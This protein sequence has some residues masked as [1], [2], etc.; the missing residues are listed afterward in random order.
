MRIIGN[1]LFKFSSWRSSGLG[2]DEGIKLIAESL[3]YV[4]SK[5]PGYKVTSM[6]ETTAGQGSSLGYKFEHLRN[7]RPCR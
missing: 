6:I 2:E 3:N 7:Y 1:T 4:H 5:T